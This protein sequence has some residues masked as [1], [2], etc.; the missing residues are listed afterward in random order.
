MNDHIDDDFPEGVERIIPPF[1]PF[2]FPGD[3]VFLVYVL[4]DKCK[5][6]V[7]LLKKVTRDNGAV[8]N[9]RFRLK[10]AGINV[11]EKVFLLIKKQ[12]TTESNTA[13]PQKVIF[14][15]SLFRV[16]Y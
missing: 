9:D 2:R 10:Q 6:I 1:F 5:H 16:G 14:G 3:D 7:N 15:S 8:L 11:A 4:G 12:I 13:I